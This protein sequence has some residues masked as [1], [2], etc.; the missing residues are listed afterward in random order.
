MARRSK[1]EIHQDRI[2]DTLFGYDPNANIFEKGIKT[3]GDY[4]LGSGMR[5]GGAMKDAVL[6]NN[7]FGSADAL[8]LNPEDYQRDW[9]WDDALDLSTAV[10]GVGLAGKAIGKGGKL[11]K[12]K[13]VKET[14]KRGAGKISVLPKANKKGIKGIGQGKIAAAASIPAAGLAADAIDNRG[15]AANNQQLDLDNPGGAGGAIAAD[16]NANPNDIHGNQTDQDILG[17]Q[18]RGQYMRNEAINNLREVAHNMPDTVNRL[19]GSGST[20]PNMPKQKMVAATQK[21]MADEMANQQKAMSRN[22][23]LRERYDATGG[24]QMGAWD[25]LSPAQQAMAARNYGQNSYYDSNPNATGGTGVSDIARAELGMPSRE[26]QRLADLDAAVERQRMSNMGYGVASDTY[27]G[28]LKSMSKE[29]FSDKTGMYTP[30]T[31]ITRN[32][33]G[34]F[35]TLEFGDTF[36]NSGGMDTAEDYLM[37]RPQQGPI[38]VDQNAPRSQQ[39]PILGDQNAA[40]PIGGGVAGGYDILDSLNKFG[41]GSGQAPVEINPGQF[42]P[43]STETTMTDPGTNPFD[44]Q[45]IDE[46]WRNRS[47][48]YETT[49]TPASYQAPDYQGN[50]RGAYTDQFGQQSPLSK[51]TV[52][53]SANEQDYGGTGFANA[54]DALGYLNRGGPR[55]EPVAEEAP[56]APE[57]PAPE[58]PEAPAPNSEEAP[59]QDFW[60]MNNPWAWGAGAGLGAATLFG[61]A[62]LAKPLMKAFSKKPQV[63]KGGKTLSSPVKPMKPKPETY[64]N[65]DG[66]DS[67]VFQA[68]KGNPG[69]LDDM[70]GIMKSNPRSWQDVVRQNTVGRT[71]NGPGAAQFHKTPTPGPE[72]VGYFNPFT[73]RF[74]KY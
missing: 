15:G 45:N 42:T 36:E 17:N 4:T 24:R 66:F 52:R 3:L 11:L 26:E 1:T 71:S 13:G 10:P 2:D 55:P 19:G 65:P 43:E 14:L 67:R 31:G 50:G 35:N 34:G 61:G 47:P 68:Q 41:P 74:Q 54:E 40:R 51:G 70:R 39:G 25:S 6:G 49:T 32:A 53:V 16:P 18:G 58:A 64:K 20:M 5:A 57:A 46:P 44:R 72:H 7:L 60:R 38:D 27:G 62:K 23:A 59:D 28:P 33:D 63:V 56:E 12:N 21:M 30:G 22:N 48:Q 73:G 9:G 29:E 69:G 8:G 37:G